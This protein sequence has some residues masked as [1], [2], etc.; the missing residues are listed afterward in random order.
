[1]TPSEQSDITAEQ[2]A[3]AIGRVFNREDQAMRSR[4][5][6]S[7]GPQLDIF[8]AFAKHRQKGLHLAAEILHEL[9]RK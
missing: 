1:M 8:E 9:G 3:H 5:Y 7:L 2:L 4:G 6:T